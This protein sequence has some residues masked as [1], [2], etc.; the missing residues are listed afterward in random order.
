[1]THKFKV[2]QFVR[3][4]TSKY[5][6]APAG[7]YEVIRLMPPTDNRNQYRIRSVENGT[8]RMVQEE[9]IS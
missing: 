4:E 3:I 7:R 5:L 9:E 2:G 6:G 1:M 8:E